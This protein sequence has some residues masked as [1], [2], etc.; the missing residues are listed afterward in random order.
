MEALPSALEAEARTDEAEPQAVDSRATGL[1]FIIGDK[2][3]GILLQ[4]EGDGRAV[5]G[6]IKPGSQ[7]EAL[8]VPIGGRI[9]S[10]N[11]ASAAFSKEA[12]TEQ[13]QSAA[14]PTTLI[15][16]RKEVAE[17]EECAR[18]EAV[19]REHGKAGECAGG[20]AAERERGEA[21]SRT[22]SAKAPTSP[23]PDE[24]ARATTRIQSTNQPDEEARATT[25]IQSTNQAD[26]EARAATRIQSTSRGKK[27]RSM[28]S[29]VYNTG[30]SIGK[31]A[32]GTAS[33]ALATVSSS[34]K[35]VP[36]VLQA[37]EHARGG[38]EAEEEEEEEADT[39]W[40]VGVILSGSGISTD[41]IAPMVAAMQAQ[42]TAAGGFGLGGGELSVE[43]PP[44]VRQ[45][46]RFTSW[47]AERLPKGYH[48]RTRQRAVAHAAAAER[49]RL[50]SAE[51]E[52]ADEAL[53]SAHFADYDAK[54]AI[55]AAAAER[56]RLRS[57]EYQR[58]DEARSWD[59]EHSWDAEEWR[60][61]TAAHAA[62]AER[63]RLRSAEYERSDLQLPTGAESRTLIIRDTLDDRERS[64][65]MV[66]WPQ[67][68]AAHAAKAE[69]ARLHVSFSY[70][71]ADE[72]MQNDMVDWRRAEELVASRRPAAVA[73]AAVDAAAEQ[74]AAEEADAR[75]VAKQQAAATARAQALAEHEAA[76]KAAG[77]AVFLLSF[78]APLL[79]TCIV[80]G[81]AGAGAAPNSQVVPR[82]RDKEQRVWVRKFRYDA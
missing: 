35:A 45:R 54:A 12:V 25:R 14:R 75:A 50:R 26:E 78:V 59:E 11:G 52:I 5:I 41:P 33:A 31:A 62:A 68:A 64:M 58:A 13:L 49:A 60:Q 32:A 69:R 44:E 67:R 73:Q 77:Q 17:R 66:D 21:D 74:E 37:A 36:K 46:A 1:S 15:V 22:P 51:Y 70:E 27:S 16:V 76:A 81:G 10:I 19:E 38:A 39:V 18:L 42:L 34:S 65:R 48:E 47:S 71:R 3:L 23:K 61:R 57:V 79:T 72:S 43:V 7:A 20:E 4:V 55:H 8:G 56:A 82:M 29:R 6:R 28:M 24:E 40:M 30:A 2:V 63:A 80:M 9:H 53:R